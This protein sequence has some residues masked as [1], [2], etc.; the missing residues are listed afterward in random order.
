MCLWY[1]DVIMITN[2]VNKWRVGK[3]KND[4]WYFWWSIIEFNCKDFKGKLEEIPIP[5]I[6]FP[7]SSLNTTYIILYIIY[8]IIIYLISNE[9]ENEAKMVWINEMALKRTI[10]LFSSPYWLIEMVI[11]SINSFNSR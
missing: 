1:D 2:E 9:N 5:F 8:Y 11:H 7:E 10:L 4:K 6:Y 3:F